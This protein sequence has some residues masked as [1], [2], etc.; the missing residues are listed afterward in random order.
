MKESALYNLSGCEIPA[1]A[2]ITISGKHK[3]GDV[4]VI[5]SCDGTSGA[6]QWRTAAEF[7]TYRAEREQA[8]SKPNGHPVW[9][10]PLKPRAPYS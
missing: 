10:P 7:E 2:R 1:S 6:A 9:P 4:L 8:A 5:E 3:L